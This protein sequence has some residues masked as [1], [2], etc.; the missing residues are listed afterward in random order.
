M[1]PNDVLF[2]TDEDF[3]F[4]RDKVTKNSESWELGGVA[5]LD[6]SEAYT[7]VWR[8][9]VE[10]SDILIV[11]EGQDPEVVLSL[12]GRIT[13]VSLT[14]DQYMR[15]TISYVLDG[16]SFLYWFDSRKSEM[17]TTEFPEVTNPRVSLDDRRKYN[18][19]NS[20][21]IFAY[22]SEWNK[23]CYRVQRER[24][25]IEHTLFTVDDRNAH[26]PLR[27]YTIGIAESGR[28]VFKT[29][30]REIEKNPSYR[31]LQQARMAYPE[32]A[33]IGLCGFSFPS[34]IQWLHNYLNK[35]DVVKSK[36]IPDFSNTS[37][38]ILKNKATVGSG[39]TTQG[40]VIHEQ[41][42]VDW[43]RWAIGQK[44]WST[45][46]ASG[47]IGATESGSTI[48]VNDVKEVL[49]VALEEEIFSKYSVTDVI[50]SPKTD[51]MSLKFSGQLVQTIL[52]VEIN[53][54]LYY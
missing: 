43:I 9:F 41:V 15:A 26:S 1:L 29:N 28:F 16:V 50:V 34:R 11:R 31:T 20:D 54:S 7:Y 23:L 27:I 45:M 24:Y 8:C 35:V 53:G 14:F 10:D 40:V 5:L 39:L 42:S 6:S 38:L 30:S 18:R 17:V 3:R 51:S 21:V 33:W 48:I 37:S 36:E 44:V 13:E 47:K 22:V 25:E 46:Y 4:P 12:E 19:K 2:E 49:N 32:S 52:N